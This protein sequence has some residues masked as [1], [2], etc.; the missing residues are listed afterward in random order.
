[1]YT[2]KE[3]RKVPRS[4]FQDPE[5]FDHLKRRRKKKIFKHIIF[6]IIIL[7]LTYFE[8]NY[9]ITSNVYDYVHNIME[10]FN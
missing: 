4:K 1:M 8:Y 3:R 2:G 7:V 10:A 9:N 5:C 6:I